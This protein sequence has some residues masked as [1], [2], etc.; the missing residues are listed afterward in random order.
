MNTQLEIKTMPS[1]GEAKGTVLLGHAMFNTFDY[2]FKPA[3][4][5]LAD[6]L[7]SKGYDVLAF[8]LTGYGKSPKAKKDTGFDQYV[9]D[10][11]EIIKNL[12]SDKPIYYLGHSVGSVAGLSAIAASA[13]KVNRI[14]LVAPAIWPFTEPKNTVVSVK[15][16]AQVKLMSLLSRPLGRISFKPLGLGEVSAPHGHFYQLNR[17]AE[18]SKMTSVDGGTF[19]TDLWKTIDS[20]I[21]IFSGTKDKS[22]APRES[23]LWVKNR[24][25][26]KAT[27]SE[28]DADHFGIIYGKYAAEK[29]WPKVLEIFEG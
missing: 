25:G 22:M 9:S 7:I 2:F 13:R 16:A 11:S 6:F 12:K 24:I 15:Q 23:V 14:I 8:N 18:N 4:K 21:T 10:Y 5:S 20:P 27:I 26:D 1:K 19:Y 17:W 29:V 3:G 28:V